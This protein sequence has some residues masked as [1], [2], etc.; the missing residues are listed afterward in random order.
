[1]AVVS[2]LVIYLLTGL[3]ICFFSLLVFVVLLDFRRKPGN[4]RLERL[5]LVMGLIT[6]VCMTMVVWVWGK[7]WLADLRGKIMMV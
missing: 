3:A 7:P 5:F 2:P 4:M 1:M 6:C